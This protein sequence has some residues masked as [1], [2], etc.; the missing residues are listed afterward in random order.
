MKTYDVI[1]VGA[2]PSGMISA[3]KAKEKYNKVLIIEQL[4]K[5][6]MKLKASGG[7]RCNLTNTLSV[8]DFINSFGKNGRFMFDAL[9]ILNNKNLIEFFDSIGL[10]TAIK[11]GFRVFPATHS[12]QSV[13]DAFEKRLLD[14]DVDIVCNTKIE[15][16]T[17]DKDEF[18]LYSKDSKYISK[19]VILSTG[20]FGFSTLGGNSS[21]YDIAKSFGHKIENIYPAMLPLK[22]KETWTSNCKAHTIAKAIITVNIPKYKKLKAIGDL[23]FTNN[24]IRGP[25]VLDFATHITPLF[26]KYKEVPISINMVKGK[27]EN[28]I[29]QYLK[30]DTLD[31]IL[32]KTI[33]YQIANI[34]GI[35]EYKNF[36]DLKGE[37]KNQFIKNLCKTPLTLVGC[38][39]FE[40]AMVTKGGVNLKQINPKTMQSKLIDG[41]YFCGEIVNLD[42][43]C[44]GFN[45]QWAF[46]SGYLAGM[47]LE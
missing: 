31:T 10:K 16:I 8:D 41:L 14:L 30:N 23:I 28:D 18:I 19:K 37:S 13:I 29:L 39:G 27:N 44:G 43:P 33:I 7:G 34:S 1:I 35:S 45:L 11:D 12:S 22:T 26:D 42:G 46:S 38:D 2:G 9:N 17:K 6:A 20:G 36:K 4:D 25:V 15:D 21:G 3:I 32:P 47:V 5:I 24:G 40:K